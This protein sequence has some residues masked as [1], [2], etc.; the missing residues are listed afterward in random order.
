MN[1]SVAEILETGA[2][3]LM[4]ADR[5]LGAAW[6]AAI[7]SAAELIRAVAGR[8]DETEALSELAGDDVA[9]AAAAWVKVSPTAGV[10]VSARGSSNGWI[11][12]AGSSFRTRLTAVRIVVRA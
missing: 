7:S 12:R 10:A 2:T 3:V 8:L 4:E 9:P 11:I 5:G 1:M 6:A